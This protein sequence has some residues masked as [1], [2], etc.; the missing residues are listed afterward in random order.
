M[1]EYGMLIDTSLCIACRGCQVACK[2]WN[3]MP[4]EITQNM[5]NY[6]N[7][8][9][10]SYHTWTLIDFKEFRDVAGKVHWVFRKEQCR[11][12]VNPGCLNA[13]PVP[14]AIVKDGSGAVIVN[15]NL[16]GDCNTECYDGCPWSIPRFRGYD[17]AAAEGVIP[18][19]GTGNG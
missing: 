7:P 11:H 16:C 19:G 1:V 6:K 13:C 10:L 18:I 17:Y 4:A 2:Q 15:Q 8:P 12:C 9:D 3:E 14:N 5:G